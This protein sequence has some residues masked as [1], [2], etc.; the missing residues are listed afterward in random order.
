MNHSP[1]DVL[2]RRRNPFPCLSRAIDPERSRAI[3][4]FASMAWTAICRM[5]SYFSI[6]AAA[7]GPP[8]DEQRDL[9]R[10]SEPVVPLPS[11]HRVLLKPCRPSLHGLPLPICPV[12]VP[13][14]LTPSWGATLSP[15]SPEPDLLLE[16]L[17]RQ[18]PAR[19]RRA[20]APST[21]GSRPARPRS[22]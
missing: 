14:S 6:G 20:P 4:R 21:P 15:G 8:S 19:N 22:G 9:H 13:L 17:R 10:R 5:G 7:R 16:D 3:S 18:E 11:R 12:F 1:V 2:P